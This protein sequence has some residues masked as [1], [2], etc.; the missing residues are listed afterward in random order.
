VL[1]GEG[2][3]LAYLEQYAGRQNEAQQA[4]KA[5][6]LALAKLPTDTVD[7][8][9]GIDRAREQYALLGEK[10]PHVAILRYAAPGSPRPR[11]N[12]NYG[13]ATVLLVFPEWCAQCRR[14]MQPLNNFLLR[15][16]A[17]EIH[18][19]GLLAMDAD[20]AATDPFQDDKFQDLLHTPTLTTPLSTLETFGAVNFPFVVVAD[21]AGRIRFLG[22][23]A[24]NAFDAGGYVE[25]FIEKSILKR[26]SEKSVLKR[27]SPKPQA[28]APQQS[29]PGP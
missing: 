27:T 28:A 9:A 23:V 14:M 25:Q 6:D 17:D 8:Q 4:V 19:Y 2:L 29:T 24:V 13:S 26:A 22:T 11:I 21:G 20:E 3:E 12:P 10:L 5:L 18:A 7:N 15:N 1:Y 16:N